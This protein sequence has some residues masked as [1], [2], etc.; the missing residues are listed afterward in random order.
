MQR[1]KSTEILSQKSR[2]IEAIPR[3]RL[4][5]DQ[6]HIAAR[7]RDDGR[8][9]NPLTWKMAQC[10]QEKAE[11]I[12]KEP[13]LQQLGQRGA[14]HRQEQQRS[15]AGQE[16]ER[17]PSRLGGSDQSA[18]SQI[19]D[20]PPLRTNEG[21]GADLTKVPRARAGWCRAGFQGRIPGREQHES[22]SCTDTP[23]TPKHTFATARLPA[24]QP[25]AFL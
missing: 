24:K 19:E 21:L 15:S 6:C 22:Q 7:T 17:W 13:K 14:M 12:W 11:R 23:N 5:G 10:L 2:E 3:D 25:T 8:A 9:R 4:T 16:K 20:L 1:S 18:A